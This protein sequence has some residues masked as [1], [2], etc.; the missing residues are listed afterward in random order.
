MKEKTLRQL[1]PKELDYNELID[2]QTKGFIKFCAVH[3]THVEDF[4][5]TEDLV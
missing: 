4:D 5:F 3:S 2:S 1:T